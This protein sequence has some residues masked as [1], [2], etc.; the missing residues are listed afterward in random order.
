MTHT[1]LHPELFIRLFLSGGEM[2]GPGKARLLERIAE[3][4]SISAAGRDMGM[5]Y[6]RA[7]NLVE[8]MNAMFRAP[9]VESAR[10]GPGGGGATLTDTGREVL[11]LYRRIESEAALAAG[12]AIAALKAL[13]A[14]G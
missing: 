1:H 14:K 5:S 11:A 3:T 9:L 4:G 12:P 2:I 7:W 13:M 6:R 8:T 10:G